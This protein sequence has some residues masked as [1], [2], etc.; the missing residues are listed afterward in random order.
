VPW[1]NEVLHVIG[2]VILLADL[3]VGP[4]RRALAWRAIGEI[5]LVPI[6]WV[7]YTLVRGP[8]TTN[9]ATGEAFWYPYPFLNPNLPGSSYGT[10]AVY[11][12]GIAVVIAL[13]AAFVVWLGRRRAAVV[14]PGAPVASPTGSA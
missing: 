9:P 11:V 2:P 14:A 5:V 10:V 6:L 7:V 3:F 13:A 12:V 1:S 8:L 4:R